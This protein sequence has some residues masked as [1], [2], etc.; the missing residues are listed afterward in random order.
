MFLCWCAVHVVLGCKKIDFLR[1]SIRGCIGYWT[2]EM[3]NLNVSTLIE[4]KE[5]KEIIQPSSIYSRFKENSNG[6]KLLMYEQGYC[7]SP[8]I[9][10]MPSGSAIAIRSILNSSTYTNSRKQNC[11][12]WASQI[13]LFNKMGVIMGLILFSSFDCGNC[14]GIY[15]YSFLHV[16]WRHNKKETSIFSGF[17]WFVLFY[18]FVFHFLFRF[19]FC[20]AD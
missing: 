8:G 12:A 17:C 6:F 13:L 15:F 2:F 11:S 4:R 19:S 16:L 7:I 3:G 14:F 1:Y 5:Y 20:Y 18:R 9:I 10:L